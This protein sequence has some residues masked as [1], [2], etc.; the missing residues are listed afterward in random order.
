MLL[1]QQIDQTLHGRERRVKRVAQPCGAERDIVANQLRRVER[2]G[3]RCEGADARPR[4]RARDR[5]APPTLRESPSSSSR[6]WL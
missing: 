6:S 1:D 3:R 4:S 5:G 2:L